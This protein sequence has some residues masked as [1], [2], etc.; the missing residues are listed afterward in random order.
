MYEVEAL[1]C[2]TPDYIKPSILFSQ[3]WKE[4]MLFVPKSSVISHS[5]VLFVC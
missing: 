5:P 2:T 4:K 3:I 1:V